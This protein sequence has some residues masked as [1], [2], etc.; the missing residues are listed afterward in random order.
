MTT[1]LTAAT[2]SRSPATK[3]TSATIEA[4]ETDPMIRETTKDTKTPTATKTPIRMQIQTYSSFFTTIPTDPVNLC[5][6]TF[7]N[8]DRYF[9]IENPEKWLGHLM[10]PTL[11][12]FVVMCGL[13]LFPTK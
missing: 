7:V 9:W 4:T 12:Q 3:T 13:F 6:F 10:I 2:K 11:L 5:Y 1:S 8:L